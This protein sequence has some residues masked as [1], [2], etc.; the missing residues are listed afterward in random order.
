[1]IEDYEI[2]ERVSQ[3][4]DALTSFLRI[5]KA[6]KA[7]DFQ[8]ELECKV[9]IVCS[10]IMSQILQEIRKGVRILLKNR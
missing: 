6:S 8:R 3:L 5:E 2:K 10:E 4:E 1:M 7:S 9:V